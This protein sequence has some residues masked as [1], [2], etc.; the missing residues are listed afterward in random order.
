MLEGRDFFVLTDHKPLTFAFQQKLERA[1]PRQCRQ[2]TYISEFTTDIRHVPGKDNVVA[3]ALSRVDAIAMPTIVDTE[4][5]AREQASDEELQRELQSQ[6]STLKLQRFLL[7]ET[8]ATLYCDCSTTEIRPFVPASLRRRIFDMVH[9]MSHPSGRATRRQIAQKFVWTGMNKDITTWAKAC[10]NCQRAKIARH[11]HFVPEKLRVPDARFEHVHLDIIGPL[12]TAQGFKYCLTLIDRFSRWP[13]AIPLQDISADTIAK[14][15]FAS[16]ISR[17][18][19]PQTITTDRGAQFE[20]TLFSALTNL[21]GT[22]RIRT[23]AYHPESNGLIERWHR[24]LKTAIM[25]QS[26]S[27]W[28][29]T[30]PI[31]LLGLRTCY[32][33][34]IRASTAELLYGKTLRIPGEFFDLEDMPNDP[35]FFV[36]PFRRMM[37]QIR[38]TPTAH[39]IRNKPFVYKDLYTCTHVFLRDDTVKRPLEH[40]YSGPH[41]VVKRITDRVFTIDVDGRI[42]NVTVDRLKPA[43]LTR[44]DQ[45]VVPDVSTNLPTQGPAPERGSPEDTVRL[46]LKTYPGASTK[47]KKAVSFQK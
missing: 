11:N 26:N 47:D 33:E 10:L 7:P 36:E 40:P 25:C 28:V 16:W 12:P 35:H 3:D 32:K 38:P 34:D 20:A 43:F 18:G 5:L 9:R 23:T 8:N 13:E 22:K 14:H 17:F 2:L 1:S 42:T 31:V 44:E 4:E 24:S 41:R 29:A 21:V 15:F 6:S 46:N 27:D 45:S 19:A 30:L 37:Q 39:H